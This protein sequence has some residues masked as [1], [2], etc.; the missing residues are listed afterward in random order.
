M[1]YDKAQE[2]EDNL[3]D[4][5]FTAKKMTVGYDDKPLIRDIEFSLK[6]G[7][8]LTLIGPN[9]AGK[10]TIL[11]S[12]TRQ[13]KLL[14]GT[15]YIDGRDQ[16]GMSA[17]A[18]ARTMAVVTTQRMRAELM[19][20]E[21]VVAS[22]RYPYTGRFG[23]LGEEDRQ[24]VKEAMELVSVTAIKDRDFSRISDGQR[25]RIMLAR[26]ICQQ[27]EIIVL[28]EPTS[29]LDIKYKLEFLSVL[30]RLKRQKNLTVVMS[31]HELDLAERISDRILCVDGT[32]VDRYGSPDEI[33]TEGYISGLFGVESGTY[34]EVGED[35]EL[36]PVKEDPK[37]FVIAGGGSGRKTF[38]RL[39]RSGTGFYTGIIC[40][41]D[42]DYPAAKAL[43]AGMAEVPEFEPADTAVIEQAKKLM[44]SCDRVI[45]T[46]THFGTYETY[47]KKLYEYALSQGKLR[48][49]E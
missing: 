5:Y 39:Q 3:M 7:E 40:Q 14:D 44:D 9:G 16:S 8:I 24:L 17:N 45:C 38:R 11:N 15:V 25:Q 10:S 19:T 4:Y 12:I 30:Q 23:L 6:K 48:M 46:R 31:L 28:D 37:I 49:D 29:Y 2:G 1:G 41:N 26:A 22:G 34:D 13:L 21:D 35:I 43:S 32:Y 33:F 36:A 27:P 42:L 20:C 18:L 47:N